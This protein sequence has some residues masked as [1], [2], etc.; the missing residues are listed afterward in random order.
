MANG[1]GGVAVNPPRGSDFPVLAHKT[2][3]VTASQQM[4]RG[5]NATVNAS[6]KVHPADT[7]CRID[8]VPPLNMR[9]ESSA[10]PKKMRYRYALVSLVGLLTGCQSLCPL[11]HMQSSAPNLNAPATQGQVSPLAT[12]PT[13]L[14]A[15]HQLVP[16]TPASQ[17]F[18][19]A[20]APQPLSQTPAPQPFSQ[21]PAPATP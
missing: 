11:R 4:G 5:Q 2:I 1:S 20:L 10:E 8:I 18:S 15:P 9:G 6:C 3:G 21:M 17:P 13:P 7:I 12:A 19:Q 16:Q 14:S